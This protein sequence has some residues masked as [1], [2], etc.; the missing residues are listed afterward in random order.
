LASSDAIPKWE[1]K[2]EPRHKIDRGHVSDMYRIV[3][4]L[5]DHGDDG[6]E[7]VVIDYGG[8]LFKRLKE[9]E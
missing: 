1:Y 2:Y 6:W 8:F 5:N 4:N 3:D 9:E 7:L